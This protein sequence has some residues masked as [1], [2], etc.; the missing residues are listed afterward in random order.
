VRQPRDG[1]GRTR[2]EGRG[3][4]EGQG[5]RARWHCC[6]IDEGEEEEGEDEVF[7]KDAEDEEADNEDDED[8]DEDADDED[9]DDE[10]GDHEDDDEEE[11]D[12]EDDDD[13]MP[14]AW[15]Q[16]QLDGNRMYDGDSRYADAHGFR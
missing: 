4:E 2:A 6:T 5:D 3:C 12:D 13:S 15:H 9:A 14:R 16:M 11:D 8:A 10:D 7:D 1:C